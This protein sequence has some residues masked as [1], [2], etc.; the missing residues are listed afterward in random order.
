MYWFKSET[1]HIQP[2]VELKII[3]QQ[4]LVNI[5]LNN[6]TTSITHQRFWYVFRLIKKRDGIS[7]A[8]TFR[9][10][11][12]CRARISGSVFFKAFNLIRK[13]EGLRNEIKAMWVN[14][15]GN[16][17]QICK[18]VFGHYSANSR[19]SANHLVV[20]CGKP[21]ND[22]LRWHSRIYP[23][24]LSFVEGN[25][26][27]PAWVVF[28]ELFE[29]VFGVVGILEV[30]EKRLGGGFLLSF[31]SRIWTCDLRL[32]LLFFKFQVRLFLFRRVC[33]DHF[34]IKFNLH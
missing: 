20:A 13:K 31:F 8:A 15:V 26:S 7:T 33:F 32:L 6:Q 19:K 4:R 16:T 21:L 11:D 23:S 25:H 22:L 34:Y 5:S 17:H 24:Q 3:Q 27:F 1:A 14:L 18:H 12:V 30:N 2:Q 28:D 10:G 9:F 29:K